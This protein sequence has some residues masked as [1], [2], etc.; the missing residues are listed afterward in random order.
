MVEDS[1]VW[2]SVP[3]NATYDGYLS[4]TSGEDT[5]TVTP[6][7]NYPAFVDYEVC[8]PVVGSCGTIYFCDT[9][10]VTFVS[11]FSVN[12]MPDSPIVCF[13]GTPAQLYA[14]ISGGA[15]PYSYLWSNGQTN[16]TIQANQG[17]YVVQATDSLGCISVYDTVLVDSFALP[18]QATVGNDTVFC[19][20]GSYIDLV[21]SVQ[22]ATGGRWFGGAGIYEPTDTS[23][24]LRYYPDATD[25]LLGKINLSLETTGNRRCPSDTDQITL[26]LV[27]NPLAEIVGMDTVCQGDMHWWSAKVPD[28]DF[29]E[30]FVT[31]GG[32]MSPDINVDSVLIQ[33]N[34]TGVQTITLR[35]INPSNCDSVTTFP[36]YVVPIPLPEITGADTA[37]EFENSNYSTT[38]TGVTYRWSV[39]GGTIVGSDNNQSVTVNWNTTGTQVVTLDVVGIIGCLAQATYNVEVLAKPHPIIAGDD[40]TCENKIFAYSIT[41]VAGHTYSW[42]V[43]GG[44]LYGDA[45]SDNIEVLWGT[46]GNGSVSIT[47]TNAFG[48]D[49]AISLPVVVFPTPVPVIAGLTDTS[50][51]NKIQAYSITP[52]AGHTYSW[53]VTGGA[54]IGATNGTSVNVL[55][56]APGTGTLAVTQTSDFGCDSTVTADVTIVQTPKP[57][58]SLPNDSACLNKIYAYSVTPVAGETYSWNVS[59]GSIIGSSSTNS[60]NVLWTTLGTG[61]VTV[62][63]SSGFGCDS[64]VSANVTIVYTPVPVIN[65]APDTVCENKINTYT[66]TVLPGETIQWNVSGGSIVGSS[67]SGSVDVLWATPGTGSLGVTVISPFGCDSTI[68]ANVVIVLTP[69]PVIS[70]PNDTACLNKIYNYAVTPVAG[71][72]YLWSATNGT[73]VGSATG[74]SANVLWTGLG[75]GTVQ[76]TQTSASG[77]DSTVTADVTIVYTPVPVVTLPNDTACENKIYNYSLTLAAG[78]TVQWNVSGGQILG[79]A[80]LNNINVLWAGPGT[81][82]ISVTQTSA[83]G[84]DSTITEFVTIVQT[85]K[86]IISLPNDSACENKIETYS[87]TPV[88]GETYAWSAIGGTV[89][90]SNTGS[91]ANILWSTPGTGTVQVT[92]TSSFGCDSTVTANVTILPTA[93]PAITAPNDT[94]CQNN[95]YA[96]SVT[97]TGVHTYSWTAVGG[98][99]LGDNTDPSINVIWH[100]TGYQTLSITQTS[101]FG[102]D[103]TVTDTF[104]INYTPDALIQGPRDSV[105]HNNLYSYGVNP[106]GAG[107]TYQWVVTGGIIVGSSTLHTVNVQWGNPGVGSIQV[108]VVNAFGCDSTTL[109][110]VYKYLTPF[111]TITGTEPACENKVHVYTTPYVA[112]HTYQWTISGGTIFGRSD[113]SDIIVY[114]PS[115]GTGILTLTEAA[116]FSCDSTVTDTITIYATPTPTISLPNDTACQNKIVAYTAN[117]QV[118]NNVA[119][120]VSGGTII[121]DTTTSTI[122]VLWDVPGTGTITVTEVNGAGCDSTVSANVTIVYTPFTDISVPSDTVCE[123][124]I[125]TYTATPNQN[126]ENFSWSV[127]G[128]TIIGNTT[129][130]FIN[131]LW[132]TPGTGT[133]TLTQTSVFGCDSTVTDTVNIIQTPKPIISL[134]NDTACENKIYNYSVTPV[135][136]ETYAWTVSGGQIIGDSSSDNINVLWAGPGTGT[137]QVTQTSAFGCDSTVSANVTIVYTPYT[138]INL[139][140]DTACESKIETYTVNPIG[141]GESY[142]WAVNGGA[143]IGSATDTFI[144]VLWGT[145][146][147]GTVSLT[148]TSAFGCDSTVTDSV[149]IVQTPK[150]VISLPN[151]S[152]C[153]NK[154]Y[155]YSVTPVGGETY[156]WTVSGGTII[157]DT[158]SSS[159]N[160]MW[161]TPGTGTINLTQTSSFGCDSTVSAN[162]TIVYTPAPVMSLPNDTACE[163]KIYN[164][165]ITPQAGE[166][167]LWTVSGGQIIGDSTGNNINVLWAGPGTGT[168]QV[169]QISPFGCDSTISENV[170]IVQTPKPVISLPN[171]TAC[172]NKIYNYSVTPVAGETYAWNVAGGSIIG[173]TTGDNIN[174]LWAGPGTGTINLTQTSSFGC[175]STVSANITIVQTPKPVI[176]LPNDTACE[177]KIYNYSITPVGGET[178]Q[179]VVNGGSIIG[180]ATGDNINVLW[181]GPGTGTV[182]VTQTSTFGCDSTVSDTVT[183]VQTPKPIIALPNDTACQNK[184]YN[185]SVTPVAGESYVWTVSGGQIIG[186]STSDNINVLW[187]VPGTGTITMTQTSSF[188]CDSTVSSDV[189]IVY[190][191]APTFTPP[192]DTACENK[193]YTY[194]T[195]AVAGESYVWSVSGGT[196]LSDSTSNSITIIWGAPGTGSLS[197]T[198]ITP[199]GCDTTIVETVNIVQTPKPVI[200]LPNDSACQNKIYAYSVTPVAGES[201]AWTVSGGQIIGDTASASIAVLWGTPGTGTVSLTQTSSFGCDSTVSADVTIV[202]TPAPVMSLPNDTACEN[203]IYNYSITPQ[204]GETFSWTVNGGSIIGSNTGDNINVLWA[205]PGTGSVSV[206]QIS[207]FGCDSTITENVT[208]VQTPKP[209][210]SL[211]NDTAC[212]NKIYNYSVTPVAGETYAWNVSGGSIIGSSTGSNINVMWATPGTGT[213]EVT[214]TSTFGCDSTVSANVTIV[215]TPYTTINLPNDTACENKI[216]TYTVNPSGVG[217][218]YAWSVSGGAIIGSATDTFINVLWAGPGTGAV[219]LTQTSAFG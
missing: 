206:T 104:Y 114:W 120:T 63:Q 204:A 68:S 67:T 148:Q 100:D 201:Y 111:P 97:P 153:Q 5:V 197:L 62:T 176:S 18:I 14:E 170:T 47:Q 150:P 186:D 33:F 171:D 66:I 73:V 178:Y 122:N 50:C 106:M 181:A 79:D 214:Q 113:T 84:C 146:G 139:P 158:S 86:P 187:G 192:A 124:K 200:S 94:A 51:E 80:T 184:I 78:E 141:A 3:N 159:I 82:S 71:N 65:P 83:F 75:T 7:G 35:Q 174:V 101:A 42:N 8:G 76:V 207:T 132:A 151:D 29:K 45:S 182:A 53:N 19:N 37:C 58:I 156:A 177:N 125:Y 9:V 60:I 12:I 69:K 64:T 127:N 133:I 142:L 117:A 102:C 175:D 137:I 173:S 217:E 185:Y 119:W 190:T 193:I 147:T 167:F 11:T 162:V 89:V 130:T 13:G 126:G 194:T 163:N 87:V 129:D 155:A 218:T 209:V 213:I 138:D 99:I 180:S 210:I 165:A 149:T 6:T 17:T 98:T 123:N 161:G 152:A 203:K 116:P 164:Y 115:P 128:G 215:Y 105:C 57:V 70:I 191:P 27:D 15:P 199:F 88:A 183:I 1:I 81:G 59:G 4:A 93:S 92:Q 30:W 16:D 61:T 118:G 157:G 21:G 160:V 48:C 85:P 196:I 198:S 169:T 211:P 32:F 39:S 43:S 212:E 219:T 74:S 166:S 136:G 145:P 95:I 20:N 44:T 195:P 154:I 172:E 110:S 40:S 77:C 24:N 46:P 96:Y 108:T 144:N 38:L 56:S 49:S 2:R 202:Y 179:W 140:N 121:G 216:E 112:E 52:A 23:L 90:G 31:G 109:D 168:V 103:S 55:W 135:G 91:S 22:S 41:P 72:T 26:Y 208:I 189:T 34:D 143:I 36:V 25:K 107:E 188:G 134:P 131:V 54:I 10:R 205:G 28:I